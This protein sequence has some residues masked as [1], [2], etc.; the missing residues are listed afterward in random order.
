MN[1]S[2]TR[3]QMELPA[4]A[5]ERLVR[6][7]ERT[8]AMSYGEVTKNVFKLYE[9]LMGLTEAGNGLCIRDPDGSIRDL[10][11]FI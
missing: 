1:R 4:T 3:V 6:L 7:K 8:E 11:L 9:R 2:A 5:M 10:E